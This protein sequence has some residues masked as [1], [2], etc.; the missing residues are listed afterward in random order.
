M[1]Y[2]IQYIILFTYKR[3]SMQRQVNPLLSFYFI[4]NRII[5]LHLGSNQYTY[6]YIDHSSFLDIIFDSLLRIN[7]AL[8][9]LLD[10]ETTKCHLSVTTRTFSKVVC[11][12]VA[13]TTII[14]LKLLSCTIYRIL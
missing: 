10:N 9:F 6:L 5:F 4:T 13:V 12:L 2:M 1:I 7:S 8:H 11:Y 14:Y 3:N